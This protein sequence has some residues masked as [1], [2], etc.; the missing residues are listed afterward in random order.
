MEIRDIECRMVTVDLTA[1]E[2]LIIAQALEEARRGSLFD[3]EGSRV[4][5]GL[6][7][8]MASAFGAAAL[9]AGT[10]SRLKM[11]QMS[12]CTY[13]TMRENRMLDPGYAV[14]ERD[15]RWVLPEAAD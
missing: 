13:R 5:F 3:R 10:H 9:A 4:T 1:E 2:S 12:D 15:G 14:I 6:L 11:Q 7:D 8:A